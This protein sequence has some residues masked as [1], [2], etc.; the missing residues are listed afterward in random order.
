MI[1]EFQTDFI[2]LITTGVKVHTIRFGNRWSAGQSI[3][4]YVKFNRLAGAPAVAEADGMDFHARS[5]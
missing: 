4:F 1:L 5:D 2:P 3:K